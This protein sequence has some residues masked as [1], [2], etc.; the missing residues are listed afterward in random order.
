MLT[1]YGLLALLLIGSIALHAGTQAGASPSAHLSA[2]QT[3]GLRADLAQ[4]RKSDRAVEMIA[5][6]QAIES[7][8]MLWAAE[9]S[10][11]LALIS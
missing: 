10:R 5:L 1:A 9:N 6:E 8:S 2:M 4:R 7:L 11:R 3:G